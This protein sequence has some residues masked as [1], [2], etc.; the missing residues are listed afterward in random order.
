MKF[1]FLNILNIMAGWLDFEKQLAFYASYH[2]NPTNKLIHVICVPAILWSAL[3][4]LQ[5]LVPLFAFE[6]ASYT[7]QVT[8]PYLVLSVY[9]GYYLLLEPLAAATYTP[10]LLALGYYSRVFYVSYGSEIAMQTALGVHVISWIAQFAGHAFAEHRAPALLD[11]LVQA[12]MLAP[13]FVWMEVLFVVFGYRPKLQHRLDE[14]VS[15]SVS[16]WKKSQIA[17]QTTRGRSPG[18]KLQKK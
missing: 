14:Q 16:E 10:F 6:L 8:L 7:L 5:P 3:V 4:F 15:S 2:R 12:L 1:L 13:L 11:G 17:T 9:I 18:K